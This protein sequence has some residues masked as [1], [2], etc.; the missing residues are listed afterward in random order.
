VVSALSQLVV[1]AGHGAIAATAVHNDL[2]VAAA[3]AAVA[4]DDPQETGSAQTPAG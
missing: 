2:R 4:A 1:A 3:A